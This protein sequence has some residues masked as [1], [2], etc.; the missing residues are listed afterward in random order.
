VRPVRCLGEVAGIGG[1]HLESRWTFRPRCAS[2]NWGSETTSNLHALNATA[3]KQPWV[4]SFSYGRA[5]QTSV[6]QAWRGEAANKSAAQQML[7]K[8]A[9]LNS[10][11]A[12][13]QYTAAMKHE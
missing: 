4:L 2:L 7:S 13:G 1:C 6:L 9:R 11:A 10:A 5:L 12:Q 3:E 8:R